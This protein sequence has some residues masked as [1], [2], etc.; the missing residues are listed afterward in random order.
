LTGV[1]ILREK[2]NESGT[3][4]S[5]LCESEE[6]ITRIAHLAFKSAQNRRKKVTMVDKA[7]VLETSRLWRRV[8]KTV[9]ESYP[10]VALDLFVCR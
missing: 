5:D 9:S 10:D 4:A 8:V 6:E 2:L 1:L 7:N 3:L